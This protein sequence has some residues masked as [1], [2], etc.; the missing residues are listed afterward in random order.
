MWG[1]H[2]APCFSGSALPQVYALKWLRLLFLRD[3]P[4]EDTLLVWDA[5]FA[6]AWHTGALTLVAGPR[7]TPWQGRLCLGGKA[8]HSPAWVVP[9][10]CFCIPRG[11]QINVLFCNFQRLVF[12]QFLIPLAK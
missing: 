8:S 9:L 1:G 10:S 2:F 11:T 4:L 7:P 12:L 3:F 5:I 6:D